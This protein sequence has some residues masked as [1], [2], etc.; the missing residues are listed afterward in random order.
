MNTEIPQAYYRAARRL[1]RLLINARENGA[2][3]F[4]DAFDLGRYVGQLEATCRAFVGFDRATAQWQNMSKLRVWA[5]AV[6]ELA[7]TG[8][9]VSS[10]AQITDSNWRL[11]SFLAEYDPGEYVKH[12]VKTAA[13]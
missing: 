10:A 13:R 1:A 4:D 3:D 5:L 2:V 7:R 9:P 11:I 8:D 12:P 6:A